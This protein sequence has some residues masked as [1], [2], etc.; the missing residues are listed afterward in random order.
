MAVVVV[1]VALFVV[2]PCA[3]RAQCIA[4]IV[5]DSCFLHVLGGYLGHWA[6]RP[7]LLG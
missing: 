6:V 4:V 3:S 7:G 1:V 2:D 5:V